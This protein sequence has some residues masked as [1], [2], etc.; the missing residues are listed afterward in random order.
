MTGNRVLGRIVLFILGYPSIDPKLVSASYETDFQGEKHLRLHRYRPTE[1]DQVS[2][3][4]IILANHSSYI[5]LIIMKMLFGARFTRIGTFPPHAVIQGSVLE[6]ILHQ[7]SV[8]GEQDRML[9]IQIPELLAE[10]NRPIVIFPEG[11]RSNGRALLRLSADLSALA[12]NQRI[13]V[14]SL[15]HDNF[16]DRALS[17][18][19]P[20]YTFPRLL[21]HVWSMLCQWNNIV[22]VKILPPTSFYKTNFPSPGDPRFNAALQE[23]LVT[24]TP[25]MRL[26]KFNMVDKLSFNRVYLN[27]SKE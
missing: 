7:D 14:V 4:D 13:F 5:D 24:A 3:G 8:M 25:H 26:S 9:R 18:T 6:C 27:R 16:G 10:C 22:G 15:R 17:P 23:L 1:A 21:R 11:T 12:P 20:V 2:P 19:F